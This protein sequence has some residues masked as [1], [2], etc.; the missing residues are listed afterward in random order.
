M[1]A[2]SECG[3]DGLDESLCLGYI[4]VKLSLS[5]DWVAFVEVI[6]MKIVNSG[7]QIFFFDENGRSRD[8]RVLEEDQENHRDGMQIR[9]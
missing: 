6:V 3:R 4:S 9:T 2:R 1:G 7:C 5:N 8:I